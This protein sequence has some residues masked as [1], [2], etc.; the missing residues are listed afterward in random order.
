MNWRDALTEGEM[1]AMESIVEQVPT[2]MG[3]RAAF[4]GILDK[5]ASSAPKYRYLFLRDDGEVCGSNNQDMAE[6]CGDSGD[7]STMVLDVVLGEFYDGR[8][9]EEQ[10]DHW[11][12]DADEEEEE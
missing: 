12:D 11:L 9:V 1:K 2:T 7:D 4:E 5:L 10:E 8:A 3:F 6:R